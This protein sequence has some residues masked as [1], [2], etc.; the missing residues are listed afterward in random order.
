ML[1]KLIIIATLVAG[2]AACKPNNSKAARDYNNDIIAKENI[3]EPDVM[4]AES[5]VA[6]YNE[7]G[8]FDSIAAVGEKMESLV[9]T[10]ID[11]INA[12]PVPKAKGV[13]DFKAAMI[14]YFRFI[15][16]RYTNYKEFGQAGTD[17]KRQEVLLKIQNMVSQKQDILNEMQAAQRKFAEANNFKLERQTY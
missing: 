15:K 8:Q 4:A 9:Q 2:M 14:R 16:S 10:T 1:K 11:E 12:L 3:L 17:E 6:K 5:N 7:A 13:D